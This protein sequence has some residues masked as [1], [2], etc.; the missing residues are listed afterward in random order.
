M[1]HKYYDGIA[2]VLSWT[3]IVFVPLFGINQDVLRLA[4][5]KTLAVAL[6]AIQAVLIGLPVKKLGGLNF[7]AITSLAFCE[8]VI[9]EAAQAK[10]YDFPLV[11]KP[12]HPSVF[13]DKLAKLSQDPEAER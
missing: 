13:L 8:A 5:G 7:M 11:V 12:V 6:L 4:A 3:A 10:G 9:F 2:K 1:G